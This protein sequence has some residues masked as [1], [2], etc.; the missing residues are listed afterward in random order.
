MRQGGQAIRAHDHDML[1]HR[2]HA[3]DMIH[4]MRLDLAALVIPRYVRVDGYR[5]GVCIVLHCACKGGVPNDA[6]CFLF[7]TRV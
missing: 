3:T 1:V 7:R 6:S 4:M 5:G 2:R